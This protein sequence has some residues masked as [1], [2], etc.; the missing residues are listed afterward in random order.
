MN[1]EVLK[2]LLYVTNCSRNKLSSTPASSLIGTSRDFPGRE[3]IV[4]VLVHW[5]FIC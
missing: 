1:S 5:R 3:K 2:F 4:V